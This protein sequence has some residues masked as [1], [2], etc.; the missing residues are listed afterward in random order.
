VCR[1]RGRNV[2]AAATTTIPFA[3][4]ATT[5]TAL[6]SAPPPYPGTPQDY[7]TQ[8]QGSTPTGGAYP[9]QQ[10]PPYPDEPQKYQADPILDYPPHDQS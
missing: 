6:E 2:N 3:T 8:P 9:Q 5:Y 7:P 10:Q 1:R 4:A